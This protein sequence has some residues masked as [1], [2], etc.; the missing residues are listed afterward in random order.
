M[1]KLQLLSAVLVAAT[2]LATPALARESHLKAQHRVEN[3]NASVAPDVLRNEHSCIPAPRVGAFA[4]QPWENDPASPRRFID[5]SALSPARR[6]LS[7]GS[8]DEEK[9]PGST[10]ATRGLRSARGDA[11]KMRKCAVDFASMSLG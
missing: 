2:M 9:R 8:R 4:T 11:A 5:P 6:A 3:A 1:N 7:R 10:V